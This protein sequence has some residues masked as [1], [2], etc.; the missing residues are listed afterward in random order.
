M[1]Q[2]VSR[3]GAL[4][5]GVLAGGAGLAAVIARTHSAENHR[6]PEASSLDDLAIVLR[7]GWG[8]AAPNLET[9]VERGRYDPVT[10]RSGW[11][12]YQQPLATM[13]RMLIVHH[14]ALPA[15]EGPREIQRLH[16]NDKRYADIG[17]HF[18]IDPAG[19]IYEGRD[20]HVRGAHTGGFN[21]GTV[22]VCLMSNFEREHVS[23]Q[24]QTALARLA[25]ALR[26]TYGLTHLAGH[27]DFQP[28]ITV[29]P[30]ANL[31]PKLLALAADLNMTFGTDGY[32]G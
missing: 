23:T 2:R 13:L 3:R 6:Q 10:N 30:G 21:T 27:R 28:G 9:S 1:T 32:V 8:A 5:A 18:V 22:G 26:D 25:A 14:S 7:A 17:Y 31:A 19:T 20:I 15:T 11:R 16:Q 29:C 24:Q 4:L 12:E